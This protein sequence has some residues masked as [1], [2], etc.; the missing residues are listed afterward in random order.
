[1]TPLL[2][3]HTLARQAKGFRLSDYYL[4]STGMALSAWPACP[5]KKQ[6]IVGDVDGDS[7][8]DECV[9]RRTGNFQGGIRLPK[10]TEIGGEI[11]DRSKGHF[12]R[13]LHLRT[14]RG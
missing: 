9:H 13:S 7:A 11:V 5:Q 14:R 10:M 1:M 6:R 2:A 4:G 3:F 8:W 12:V